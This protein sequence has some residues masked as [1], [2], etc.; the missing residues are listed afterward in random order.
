MIRWAAGR[1][2]VVWATALALCL[3]GA[4]AFTRLPLA[5]RTTVELPRLQVQASWAGASAELVETY[6]TAPIESAIQSVR[7]VRKT[8]STSGEGNA[9]L[10]I[11]LEK[12]TDV[13]MARLEMLE[14]LELLRPEFPAGASPPSVSNYVPEELDEAPLLEVT[15]SGP[16]TPGAL[17]RIAE[18]RVLPRVSAVEGVSGVDL[19]G[20]AELGVSV[21]YDARRLR[22]L[23]MTPA[24]LTEAIANA[25]MVRSLGGLTQGGTERQ[26]TLR[27]QPA[28]LGELAELPVRGPSGRVF[29]LGELAAI[30]QEEDTRGFFYRINGVPAVSLT[31]ARLPGADA[32]K[33]AARVRAT[34]DELEPTLPARVDIAVATD[35]S[36]ELRKELND[37]LLRGAIA[38]V[39]V[40]VVLAL[41]L[42]RA[43]PVVLVMGS[44]AVAIAGTSL[45]LYLLGIPANLLTL[46]GLGMGVGILVQNGL[47]VVERLRLVPDRPDARAEAGVRITPAITGATLT[48][49]VVLFP[50]LYLQGNARAAFVPFAAAF[51]LA[52]GWS[53]VS[54]VVFVPAVAGGIARDGARGTRFTRWLGR[55]YAWT[56]VRLLRWR[57][58]TLTVAAALTALAGWTFVKK[59]PR[60]AWGNWFDQRTT[61]SAYL[62]FP[63]GSD[64][65][66]L[67]RGMR[68][69]ER[70]VVGVPG[71][72]QVVTRGGSEGASMQVLF[73]REA[74]LGPLPYQ[75]EE[76]LTQRAV[77]VGGAQVSVRGQG[78][79]FSAGFGG[80]G[81]VSFRIKILGFS[82]AGVEQM[83]YDL[84]ARL[85]RISRVR[86][87]DVN[88][89]SFWRREKA[90]QVTLEPDRSALARYGL[91]ASD[92]AAT[93]S[94]EVRGPVSRDRVEID[95]EELPLSLKAEGTRDRTL[96]DLGRALVPNAAGAPVRL[97]DLAR[98][99]ER[100][101]LSTISREDQQYV[102]VVSYDFRG[103]N[104]LAQRTH[105]A[106][107][108]SIGVPAGY[109]VDDERFEWEEDE[110]GK[111]LW[112]VFA[113]GVALVVLSVAFVFNSA[114]AAAM[115]LLSL[116]LALSG[117]VASFRVA[118]AAFTREAA[119]GVILVVGLAVNQA[120]L[121][122]DAA[123]GWKRG[124][125]ERRG[126]GAT[127]RH[128]TGPAVVRACLDRA[129]MI[130][131]VT[132]TTMASLIPLA[133]GS[134][135]DTLFGA[136]ALATAGGT[137]AGTIGAMFILP[138]MLAGRRTGPRRRRPGP[139]RRLLARLPHVRL[140]RLR[141]P[142]RAP[143]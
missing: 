45:G 110:S 9:S 7:G 60:S 68:E 136:I 13:Q 29:A 32:I 2:A 85:E 56:V 102:R 83:A 46:A 3:A 98:V 53:V 127:G 22:Q 11:E 51:A 129:E 59:V 117:V 37:L 131:L 82:Y 143:A 14:R 80:G 36:V 30:R 17:T 103:P 71:V 93:V 140:P 66:S 48:T 104:R 97:A 41:T 100:Q 107:M 40:V 122:V 50:F 75:M 55:G 31:V 15:L 88:A 23:G 95:G 111:G 39:A 126:D 70:I 138:T 99:D 134:A 81:S 26:V 33:T 38:F 18:D 8:S 84:K 62:S 132:L 78:P 130:I 72:E 58:A 137:V 74:G 64:P 28:A 114:W 47:V 139:F 133:V 91:T 115:V 6:L 73:T 79:G 101:A 113:V 54:A 49:A 86:D 77:L 92:F 16:Y 63:R 105:D 142:R 10:T 65:E 96:D 135:T 106:F 141:L 5:T 108:A 123:L 24:A 43:R 87:V 121:L 119:V 57:W 128:L 67:D 69:F 76:A 94:R 19:R 52:L 42:R 120:I 124:G 21:S 61:L 89:G 90:F 27:D 25:R 112:M 12:G 20:T 118:D 44:A 35:E 125:T 116:P 4:V 109:S 34:L 1:P